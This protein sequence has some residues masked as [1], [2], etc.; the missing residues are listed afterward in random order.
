MATKKIDFRANIAANMRAKHK[1]WLERCDYCS[2]PLASSREEGCLPG[3]CSMRPM[4]RRDDTE[5]REDF[6]A[7]LA[8]I[9]SDACAR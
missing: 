7:L 4:P 3:D 8:F 1:A 2:W 9:E 6:R 5:L